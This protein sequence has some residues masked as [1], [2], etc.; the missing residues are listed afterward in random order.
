[1][2]VFS[3]ASAFVPYGPGESQSMGHDEAMALLAVMRF[4]LGF[5][6][7]EHHRPFIR[8]QVLQ[9]ARPARRAPTIAVGMNLVWQG[10]ETWRRYA[11]A[12]ALVP[13]ATRTPPSSGS[14]G[15]CWRWARCRARGAPLHLGSGPGRNLFRAAE[16]RQHR[17]VL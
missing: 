4:G 17:G 5:G 15:S 1:M 16:A 11:V 2:V 13:S 8:G 10:L 7:G 14:S 9:Q 12:M 3:V 6:I